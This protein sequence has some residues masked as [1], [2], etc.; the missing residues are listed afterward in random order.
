MLRQV[1]AMPGHAKAIAMIRRPLGVSDATY[2]QRRKA[3]GRLEMDQA[4]QLRDLERKRKRSCAE[5]S[6]VL[7]MA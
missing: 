1:E 6:K 5:I 2:C 4:R 3:Y 7:L